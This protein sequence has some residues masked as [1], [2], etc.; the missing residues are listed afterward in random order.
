MEDVKKQVINVNCEKGESEV[1]LRTGNDIIKLEDQ[2]AQTFYTN[3][4]QS[5][6]SYLTSIDFIGYLYCTK[7]DLTACVNEVVTQSTKSVAVCDLE[8]SEYIGK[9]S[10]LNHKSMNPKEFDRVLKQ[11]RRYYDKNGRE[12][13]IRN[14][15][16]EINAVLNAKRIKNKDGTFEILVTR[17]NADGAHIVIPDTVVFNVP[18]YKYHNDLIAVKMDVTFDYEV[19]DGEF[20]AQWTLDCWDLDEIINESYKVIIEN[21]IKCYEWKRFWGKT[22]IF[23]QTD[24]WRYKTNKQG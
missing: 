12:L 9:I 21:Y 16:L 7:L 1:L 11:M 24:E 23:K 17:K 3:E 6:L 5:F 20:K 18:L 4:I 8:M 15:N 10:G 2:T 14:K 19:V 13:E 22:K